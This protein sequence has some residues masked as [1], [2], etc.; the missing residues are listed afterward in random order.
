MRD[1]RIFCT[2]DFLE[3]RDEAGVGRRPL[4]G[5]ASRS[6]GEF[7]IPARVRR[8]VK[9]IRSVKAN[10]SF[11]TSWLAGHVRRLSGWIDERQRKE[12]ALFRKDIGPW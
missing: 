8:L 2:R 4:L 7:L 11:A 6:V 3:W 10:W 5:H 12:K 9:A 1:Y